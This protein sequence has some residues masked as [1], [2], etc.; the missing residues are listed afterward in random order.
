M[1]ELITEIGC[2]LPNGAIV[3]AT[4]IDKRDDMRVFYLAVKDTGPHR[5]VT[6]S[7]DVGDPASTVIGYYFEDL[8][9]GWNSLQERC[10]ATQKVDHLGRPV[11]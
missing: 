10:G 1:Q 9:R 2:A 3:I 5:F 4:E 11:T 6:W 7:A 8:Q